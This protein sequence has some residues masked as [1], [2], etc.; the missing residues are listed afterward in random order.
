MAVQIGAKPDSG[1]DDPL[2]ML[3][4][5]HRR[6]ERF[7]EIVCV[8]VERAQGRALTHEEK[9]ALEAALAYFRT[10]GARHTADEE[11]SLFP[12]LR[13]AALAEK[14]TEVGGLEDDHKRANKLH[15]ETDALYALWTG[16]GS[17]NA[18]KTARL[19]EAAR[20]LK[21]LYAAHIHMEETEIFPRAA[22]VLDQ[23]TIT[24]IGQEFRARRQ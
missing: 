13:A 16:E 15:A 9:Q 23:T 10:G 6:I 21:H 3:V 20:E 8:V 19:L 5:C 4:D 22:E 17:L 2:G 12:R 7:L 1:F 11:E 14:L 18:E 24:A